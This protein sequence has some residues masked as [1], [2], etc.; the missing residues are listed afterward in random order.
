MKQKISSFIMRSYMN[1]DLQIIITVYA[2]LHNRVAYCLWKHF[3][4]LNFHKNFTKLS[5]FFWGGK[6][7]KRLKEMENDMLY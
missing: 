1:S 4:G 3:N 2:I 6:I 7:Q 5:P